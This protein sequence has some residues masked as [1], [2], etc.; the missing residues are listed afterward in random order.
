MTFAYKPFLKS[1]TDRPGI[2]QMYGEKNEIL[3]VGKAKNLKKRVTSYFSSR[4]QDK[5]TQALVNRIAHI[6]VTVTNSESEALILEQNLIKQQYPPYNILLRD[7]KSYPYIFVSEHEWPQIRFHRGAKKAKGQ[8]FGPLPSAQAARETLALIQKVFRVR[9]CDDRFFSNR[10]RPCL[11]YQIDRCRAP[12]VGMV[13]TETNVRDLD[14]SLAL[15]KGEND[16]LSKELIKDMNR[17]AEA[18]DYE[19][20]AIVRDQINMIRSIQADQSIEKGGGNLDVVSATL[21]GDE[22]CVHTLFIRQGRI[23]GSRSFYPKTKLESD[24]S[25]LLETF[26]AHHYLTIPDAMIPTELLISAE[27]EGMDVLQKALCEYSRRKI[28]VRKPQRGRGLEWLRMAGKTAEQNLLGRKASKKSYQRR[29]HNLRDGLGLKKDID[30]LECYDISHTQGS[31]TVGSCVVFDESG[32]A[33][34]D[35]RR[36]NIEGI[37]GGDDYAAMEQVLKR[38]FSRLKKEDSK[39]PDIV[40]IDGGKGQLSQVRDVFAE[41]GIEDV[42]ILGVAKGTTR[43]SGWERFYFGNNFQE[44]VLDP[45]SPGFHLLQHIRDEAHRFAI[46]GHKARRTKKFV[47]SPLQEIPGIGAKRRKTL[48]DHFGGYKGIES[49]QVSDLGK[50]EGIS[51]TMAQTIYDYFHGT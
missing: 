41:L 26:L 50:V 46:T 44:F 10:S 27:F 22:A 38:R 15:L 17:H 37:T 12:C 25:Q 21:D 19:A 5:K 2:Y 51:K 24:S 35:Y 20:A 49:A 3:Y 45:T 28:K 13:D 32:P 42:E 11:Q 34:K 4:A 31:L 1:L 23:M 6:D 18:L 7:D 30:S 29:L 39:L 47:E 16:Q 8:Y 9:Q 48:V 36:F 33:K 40:V 14:N 43:K